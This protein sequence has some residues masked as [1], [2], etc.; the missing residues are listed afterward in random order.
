MTLTPLEG[1]HLNG[2]LGPVFALLHSE[3]KVIVGGAITAPIFSYLG[4]RWRTTRAWVSAAL[5][6]GAICLEPLASAAAG[7][8]PQ[9]SAVWIVELLIGS[10]SAIYF[11]VAGRRSRIVQSN[12]IT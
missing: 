4:Y 6:T 3:A 2:S 11:V 12:H 5:V 7:R 1:V 10:V 8:L 9:F